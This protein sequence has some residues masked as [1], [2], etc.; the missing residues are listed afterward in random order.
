[1]V[2]TLGSATL[3]VVVAIAIWG[4]LRCSEDIV[5]HRHLFNMV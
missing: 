5:L 3:I 2:A 4:G 1:M